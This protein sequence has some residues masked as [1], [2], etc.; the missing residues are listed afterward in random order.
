M[1]PYAFG[2]KKIG[3][4]QPQVMLLLFWKPMI[5]R[6]HMRILRINIK[7]PRA[8]D[9]GGQELVFKDT[10]GNELGFSIQLIDRK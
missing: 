7:P 4:S 10:D 1:V 3:A 8:A 5:C 9:W 2:M 6:K